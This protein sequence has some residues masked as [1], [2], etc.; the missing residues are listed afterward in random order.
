MDEGNLGFVI[1]GIYLGHAFSDLK[2]KKLYLMVSTVWGDCNITMKY[3]AG[4]DQGMRYK[5]KDLVQLLK[6][7]PQSSGMIEIILD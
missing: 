4:L 3:L 5:G 2:G 6:D 7:V 1:D